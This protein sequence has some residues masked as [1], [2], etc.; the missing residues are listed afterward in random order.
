[1]TGCY[2]THLA[3]AGG[4]EGG[5]KEVILWLET[6]ARIREEDCLCQFPARGPSEEGRPLTRGRRPWSCELAW[7]ARRAGVRQA[8][9]IRV[10]FLGQSHKSRLSDFDHAFDFLHRGFKEWGAKSSMMN[11]VQSKEGRTREIT[12]KCPSSQMTRE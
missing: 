10:D 6:R 3:R 4:R 2:C 1:M 12:S 9:G 11:I 8:E 5:K 7:R